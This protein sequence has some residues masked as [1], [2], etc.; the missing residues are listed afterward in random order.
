MRESIFEA[1]EG[2]HAAGHSRIGP[3]ITKAEALDAKRDAA[4]S[5]IPSEQSER[6]KE[7]RKRYQE[8]KRRGMTGEDMVFL[9][10]PPRRSLDEV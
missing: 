4:T 5:I 7:K 6:A 10:S 2:G 8:K 9:S 1:D 3:L